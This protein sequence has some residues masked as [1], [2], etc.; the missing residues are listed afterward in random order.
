MTDVATLADA[1]LP[2]VDS[3]DSNIIIEDGD[4][5]VQVYKEWAYVRSTEF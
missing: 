5:T 3:D 1:A 2:D 4:G